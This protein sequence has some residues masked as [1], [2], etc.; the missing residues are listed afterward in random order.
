MEIQVENGEQIQVQLEEQLGFGEL[1]GFLRFLLEIRLPASEG[2]DYE[3]AFGC[4]R[5]Q[6]ALFDET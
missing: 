3:A 2:S 1:S 6:S 5:M 4:H